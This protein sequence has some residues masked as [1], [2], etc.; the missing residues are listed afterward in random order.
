MKA[1][2]SCIALALM[3]VT[4]VVNASCDRLQDGSVTLKR[5]NDD[6]LC[7]MVVAKLGDVKDAVFSLG[8]L[9]EEKPKNALTDSYWE[10]WLLT[11]DSAPMLTQQVSKSY[12]GVG[13]WAPREVLSEKDEMST[14]D[15]LMSQ[16]VHFGVGFG[17]KG[18]EPRLRL[19]YRWH[20]EFES[21]MMMQLEVPF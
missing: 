8:G 10:Q 21:D 11:Q 12:L 4:T 2:W 16:G 3:A 6:S 9:I 19:D 7:Y 18:K 1:K 14:Q 15:W 13:L 17:E 20:H 5:S